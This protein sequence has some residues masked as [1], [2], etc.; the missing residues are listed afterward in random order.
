MSSRSTQHHT[1]HPSGQVGS[2]SI[3]MPLHVALTLAES[4]QRLQMKQ[5][6]AA[7]AALAENANYCKSIL[8]KMADSSDLVAQWSVLCHGKAKRYSNLALASIEI[9]TESWLEI[10]RQ[11]AESLATIGVSAL[12]FRPPGP[13]VVQERRV[14]SQVI[15]FPDR[16]VQSLMARAA[17][18]NLSQRRAAQK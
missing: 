10:N 9:M 4:R 6:D 1:R 14:S 18:G 7:N 3:E 17:A 11:I 2:E 8:E 5:I 13:E 12:Q 15:S 16:R